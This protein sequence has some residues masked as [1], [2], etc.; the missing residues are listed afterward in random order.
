MRCCRLRVTSTLEALPFISDAQSIRADIRRTARPNGGVLHR[1]LI[2]FIRIFD[3]AHLRAAQR[4]ICCV[5]SITET[6]TKTGQKP[7][8]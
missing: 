1:F 4:Q 6:V 3:L 5:P 2:V 7:A 8:E